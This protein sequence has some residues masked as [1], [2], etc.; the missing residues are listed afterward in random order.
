MTLRGAGEAAEGVL[1]AGSFPKEKHV[2]GQRAKQ[3]QD[4]ARTRDG[5]CTSP[6]A[7]T[8]P[9]QGPRS[10]APALRPGSRSARCV[11]GRG[12]ETAKTEGLQCRPEADLR[13]EGA[14]DGRLASRTGH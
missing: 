5:V 9:E 4:P 6:R 13:G 11:L 3:I 10:F 7:A 8:R 14:P 1:C 2:Y 12:K